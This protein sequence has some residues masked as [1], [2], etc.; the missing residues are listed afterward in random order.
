MSDYD[1]ERGD[2]FAE[3]N[4]PTVNEMLVLDTGAISG[5]E[6]VRI[7]EQE[8]STGL[9]RAYWCKASYIQDEL[10]LNLVERAGSVDEDELKSVERHVEKDAR[11][12]ANGKAALASD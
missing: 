7:A 8:T 9:Y 2:R 11:A 5:Y 3:H 12:R 6:G 1:F 10:N 4:D